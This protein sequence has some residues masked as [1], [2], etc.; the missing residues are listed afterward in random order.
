MKKIITGLIQKREQLAQNIFKLT[1]KAPE[2]TA[3]AKP[4]QFVNIY[5]KDKSTLLP[6]PIS[7]CNT[8]GDLL[9]LVIAVVG[10]GTAE[11]FQYAE[12]QE[13]LLSS[14]LGNGFNLDI[15]GDKKEIAVVGGGVGIPPMLMTAKILSEKHNV[16]AFLGYR[17]EVFLTEEFAKYCKEVHIATDSGE[18]GFK[19][20]VVQL[21]K[22]KN[23]F[24]YAFACGPKPMLR[25]L[26][27][28][29][30]EKANAIPLQV[31][32]EERM[33][34]GYGACVGCVCKIK[35]NQT[36]VHKRICTEGPVFMGSEVIWE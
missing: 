35:D 7:I 14:P 34:C 10:S 3:E 5:P 36:A 21:I 32:L 11:F 2:I 30:S 26:T 13:I 25:A 19:G 15:S 23:G 9:S 27:E 16:T 29:T 6:R 18:T 28:Y 8:E 12:S 1:V 4:G 20:N 22:E 17:S 31:S 24:D 33:G